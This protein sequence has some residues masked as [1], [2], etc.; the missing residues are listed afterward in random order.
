MG[1]Q[2]LLLIFF[3]QPY[4]YINLQPLLL[5]LLVSLPG[6]C[7]S[8]SLVLLNL[9]PLATLFH[10]IHLLVTQGVYTEEIGVHIK[11][12]LTTKLKEICCKTNYGFLN[13]PIPI[14]FIK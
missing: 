7:V 1:Q 8:W 10:L 9:I 12:A 4:W 3:L 5:S 11:H 6:K 14:S 13:I 2:I